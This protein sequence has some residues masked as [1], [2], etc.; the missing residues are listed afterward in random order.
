MLQIMSEYRRHHYVPKFLLRRFSG[1]KKRIDVFPIDKRRIIPNVGIKEQCSEAFFYGKDPIIEKALG[2]LE[3]ATSVVIQKICLGKMSS[4]SLYEADL[5]R[6]FILYQVSRTRG[7]AEETQNYMEAL[8]K[9]MLKKRSEIEGIPPKLPTNVLD[10]VNIQFSQT[11]MTSLKAAATTPVLAIS[12]LEF[13]F[14]L[15]SNEDSEFILSD[16][17]AIKY[18][19]FAE[20]HPT[21]SVIKGSRGYLLKGLQI[22]LPVSP[23]VCIALFDPQVYSYGNPGQPIRKISK[24]DVATLNLLQASHADKCLYRSSTG[25]NQIELCR[26]ADKRSLLAPSKMTHVVRTKEKTEPN[27]KKSHLIIATSGE[28]RIGQKMSFVEVIDKK[29]YKTTA[30]FPLRSY[31]IAQKIHAH[32]T[33][34]M[35]KEK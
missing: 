19:Q 28:I 20:H 11:Q 24:R 16:N 32:Q 33:R 7:A 5:L 15:P 34:L 29:P 8:S 4:I 1:D 31:E 18:N 14:L 17:P 6:Q 30:L 25:P 9:E 21:L 10:L 12:D 23:K 27:R 13:K 22:F 2:S 35:Q 26:L 3:D